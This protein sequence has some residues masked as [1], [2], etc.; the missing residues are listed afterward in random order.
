M[1]G[2]D[3]WGGEALIE[4]RFRDLEAKPHASGPWEEA[5]L[6]LR[7]PF[8]LKKAVASRQVRKGAKTQGFR[9]LGSFA[10]HIDR[11][12][13]GQNHATRG[14]ACAIPMILSFWVRL[15]RTA[16]L[17]LCDFALTAFVGFKRS[18]HLTLAWLRS[19]VRYR[20]N[21]VRRALSN[22][23]T[24]A[25]AKTPNWRRIKSFE[26]VATARFRRKGAATPLR[27]RMPSR[28]RRASTCLA[29]NSPPRQ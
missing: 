8:V 26:M 9:F 24:S 22:A 16:S 29:P 15:R 25:A 23:A 12:M 10:R 2:A 14:K 18:E 20:L 5:K 17:S 19:S 6:R 21:Q 13:A 11:I 1:T 27:A 3:R 28:I 4:R 7:A